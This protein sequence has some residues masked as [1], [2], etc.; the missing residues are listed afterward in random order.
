MKKTFLL[1]CA[2]GLVNMCITAERISEQTALSVA[3][4][5]LLSSPSSNPNIQGMPSKQRLRL[6]KSAAVN[7]SEYFVYENA[8]GEGWVMVSASDI[9]H[10]VLAFSETGHF[11]TE[12]QPDNIKVWLRGY[13]REISD[14]EERGLVADEEILEE[15]SDLLG[16]IRRAG[17]VVVG[18]L[19]QT[20]WDQDAPFCNLCPGTGTPGRNSDKA[21]SGCVA[22]AMAQV[23]NYW[24]WPVVGT[25][26]HTYQPKMST[27]DDNGNYTGETIIYQGELTANFGNTTY[28]WA[29]MR[30]DYTGSYTTAQANAV[31]TLMY[32]CGVAVEMQYGSYDYDGSGAYTINYGETY[33]DFPCAENALYTFFGYKQSTIKSYAKDGYSS[34]GYTYYQRQ[35]DSQ[36]KTLI[37]NELDNNRPIMYDGT[38]D[39]GGHSFI[40]DGYRS[41]NYYHFNWGWSGYN[42]GYFLLTSLTPGSGGAGGG[43]YD[44]SEDQSMIIGIMPDKP[45]TPVTS[46]TLNPTSLTLKIY[47]RQ[48]ISPTVLPATAAQTVTWTS[49]NTA[50]ATVEG[51]IV[52]GISAGTATITATATDESG[53]TA[54]CSVT[55][56]DEILTDFSAEHNSNITLSTDNS[57][58]ATSAKVIIDGE[59]YDA[60]KLGTAKNKGVWKI[61]IPAGTTK[62]CFHAAAWSGA[63]LT[64]ALTATPTITMSATV[65]SVSSDTGVSNNSPFTLASDVTG[66][67]YYFEVNVSDVTSATTLTFTPST[68]RF[69][70]WG[71]NLFAETT[72]D[73]SE[74]EEPEET[75]TGTYYALKDIANITLDEVVIITMS[76]TSGTFAISNDNGT[77]AAPTAVA[78]AVSRD[79]IISTDETILWNISRNGNDITF[80]PNGTTEKWLYSN[81]TNNGVRVGSNDNKVWTIDTESGYLKHSATERYLGIY[82]SQ[83]WRAYTS[84]NNNIKNQTLAFYA[85]VTPVSTYDEQVEDNNI[86]LEG[87][88]I[89][90]T[91]G[92]VLQI[93]TISGCPVATIR[94]NYDICTLPQGI[95]I[96]T[97]GNEWIKFAK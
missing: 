41:D 14:A 11:R 44:F 12:N 21:Y 3:Q 50:V 68:N 42:D 25:G 7:E 75:H 64:L 16:G 56:T 77:S 19:V 73:N 96:V 10:P 51:G 67:G 29:N 20:I 69:I 80:Y 83:D 49:S 48:T 82:N 15:W 97:N 28:D 54:T 94:D 78:V 38:S 23:M 79:T 43:G 35:T 30:N 37:K 27:Y 26:S 53:I 89:V 76:S 55:V 1:L 52:R 70:I 84:V 95:Y 72:D 90:N 58:N 39:E 93:F 59:E 81:N 87:N 66:E 45:E 46:I 33:E 61:T 18:P 34:G 74:P 17:N 65:F 57:S 86:R 40:C 4:N 63:A 5:F 31:A 13:S 47:E 60:I 32:H 2:L 24:Q 22:T 88:H 62:L 6:Q 36:W 85:K 71:V 8:D 91:S 9:A 92:S